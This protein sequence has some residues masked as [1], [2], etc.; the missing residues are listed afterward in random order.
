MGQRT[1]R[2]RTGAAVFALALSIIL[3][4][5][6]PLEAARAFADDSSME[7]L[8]GGGLPSNRLTPATAR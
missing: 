1:V 3:A 7:N 8:A 5:G 4:A 6:T 2:S